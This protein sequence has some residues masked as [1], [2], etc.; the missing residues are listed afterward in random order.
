MEAKY[1]AFELVSETFGLI[2]N[3]FNYEGVTRGK[4]DEFKKVEDLSKSIV[5]NNCEKIIKQL[6]IED[7]KRGT[8]D[9]NFSD[10]RKYWYDVISALDA[11]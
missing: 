4:L 1:K 11:L 5:K 9:S 6:E 10:M 3:T 7:C 8:W 2:T